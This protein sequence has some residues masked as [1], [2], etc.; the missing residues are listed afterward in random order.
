[1]GFDINKIDLTNKNQKIL[2][3]VMSAGV[4]GL[5]YFLLPPFIWFMT[6]LIY[7]GVL[8]VFVGYLIYNKEAF[9]AFF[10][11][12]SWEMTKKMIGTNKVGYMYR[13]HDVILERLVNLEGSITEIGAQEIKLKRKISELST[14]LENDKKDYIIKEKKN[15]P[16][17]ILRTLA[18]K[19]NLT[20]KQLD[21]FIPQA[22]S[23]E[24]KKNDLTELFNNWTADAEILKVNLDMKADEYE[25][26]KELNKATDNAKE[27]LSGNSVE[28][29]MYQESLKQIETSAT[30]YLSNIESFDR[31]MQP[32]LSDMS[33]NKE[34]SEDAGIKMIEEYKQKRLGLE[35]PQ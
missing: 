13:F 2:A 35:N 9:W 17:T 29:K 25:T 24:K 27:F 16:Q 18:N 15:S 31:K 23:T 34:I 20:Q 4:I 3:L 8:S 5:I 6:H 7:A 14:S 33:L 11:Q 19:I 1:M 12:I 28:Y 26:L 22:I 10:K 32:L 30:E 21:I